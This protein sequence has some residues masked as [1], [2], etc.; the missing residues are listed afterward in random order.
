MI[1]KGRAR[2]RLAAKHDCGTFY[3]FRRTSKSSAFVIM[4]LNKF[5]WL[6]SMS[7]WASA[8][9]G[10]S[11]PP[12]PET[13]LPKPQPKS[14]HLVQTFNHDRPMWS[15]RFDASGEFLFA[16]AHDNHMHRWNIALDKKVTL[17]GHTSWIR[18][19]TFS[20]RSAAVSR[21]VGLRSTR[22]TEYVGRSLPSVAIAGSR[23]SSSLNSGSVK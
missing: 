14:M 19:F 8:A 16:G 1:I 5:I 6:F 23:S 15:C 3:S 17:E 4:G 12:L 11:P 22:I 13:P 7:M 21:S 9:A 2:L 20:V 18:R 10:P